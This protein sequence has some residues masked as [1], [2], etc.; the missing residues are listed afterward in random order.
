MNYYRNMEA[1]TY[2]D[3]D[4]GKWMAVFVSCVAVFVFFPLALLSVY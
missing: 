4:M 1:I 3:V 2:M